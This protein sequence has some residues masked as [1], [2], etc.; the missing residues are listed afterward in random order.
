M[1]QKNK[2]ISGWNLSGKNIFILFS[3]PWLPLLG[4]ALA[5]VLLRVKTLCQS[6]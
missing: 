2:G 5:K 6:I 1:K 3:N 4:F